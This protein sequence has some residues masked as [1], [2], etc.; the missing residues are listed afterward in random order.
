MD[1][2]E[3]ARTGNTARARELLDTV[4][5]D[6]RLALV[7]QQNNEGETPLHLT[8]IYGHAKIARMLLD[9]VPESAKIALVN[10]QSRIGWT[11][12]HLAS[13]FGYQDIARMLLDAV[14]ETARL[15]LVNKQTNNGATP[16]HRA[17]YNGY[18]DIAR[19]FIANGSHLDAKDKQGQTP[20]QAARA[21]SHPEVANLIENA[22][23]RIANVHQQTKI[24]ALTMAQAYHARLG[25]GSPVAQFMPQDLLR[26][27][28]TLAGQANEQEARQPQPEPEK[29]PRWCVIS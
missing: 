12:L 2:F 17:A 25:D 5:E 7:N 10:K 28:M 20:A 6:S 9:A 3:A 11:S 29:A 27:V 8:V 23:Q 19:I 13:L 26:E 1:I 14:P 18:I 21:N 4:Q 24:I 15:A 22:Q 16:L